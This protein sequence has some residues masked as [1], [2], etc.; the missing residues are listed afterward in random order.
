MRTPNVELHADFMINFYQK[1]NL[2]HLSMLAA[3]AA[4]TIMILV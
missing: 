3:A 4:T 2:I 1:I